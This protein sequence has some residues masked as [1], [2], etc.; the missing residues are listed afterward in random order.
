MTG[1][2]LAGLATTTHAQTSSYS[3]TDWQIHQGQ[4][5]DF[6]LGYKFTPSKNITVTSLG[7]WVA[8]GNAI[9]SSETVGIFNNSGTL[10]FSTTYNQANATLTSNTLGD[11]S[12]FRYVD[13]SALLPAVQRTLTAGSVYT[14]AGS[15][16]H[17]PYFL[18]GANLTP[19]PD[20]T[21]PSPDSFYSSGNTMTGPN[22]TPPG[23]GNVYNIYGVNFQYSTAG[24]AV[25]T[26]EPGTWALLA[27]LTTGGLSFA[28]RRRKA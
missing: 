23:N 19:A 28:R 18:D 13:I 12:Q 9:N 26:P 24:G 2:L 25:A 6:T 22:P 20:I 10:L 7:E 1:L 17:N 4:S 16:T 21:L 14:M 5:G 27:G 11:G 8:F 3:M 15:V